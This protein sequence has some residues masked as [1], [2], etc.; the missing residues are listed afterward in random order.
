MSKILIYYYF[1]FFICIFSI[2][3]IYSEKCSECLNG[4]DRIRNVHFPLNCEV[5]IK[6]FIESS[7]FQIK[8]LVIKLLNNTRH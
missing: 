7:N 3:K 4:I 2:Q 6:E 1:L 8:N 5:Y